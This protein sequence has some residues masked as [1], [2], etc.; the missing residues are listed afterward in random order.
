MSKEMPTCNHTDNNCRLCGGTLKHI[1]NLRIL[2]RYDIN[3]F[4]CE[5]CQ[6]AQTENPYWLDEAYNKANEQNL[7]IGA[8]QRNLH[9]VSACYVIAKLF[10]LKNV[11]DFGG[12]EGLLCRMLR[13]YGANCYVIDKYRE[14]T[15]GKGF[16][17]PDFESPDLLLAFELLEHFPNPKSDLEELFNYNPKVLMFSTEI[18]CKQKQ[19]WWYFALESGQHVFFYSMKSLHFL[20]AKYSYSLLVSGGF[21]I[22]MKEAS[23][24]KRFI[25]KIVLKRRLIRLLR[26]FIPLLPMRGVQTDYL[27]QV[28][29][30]K[31]L[32]SQGDYD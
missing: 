23:H 14:P 18:Y 31:S 13:D 20:A 5:N 3:Y 26:C 12:G 32:F 2:H 28:E 7:D 4:E 22:F 15:Y 6:S 19:D 21:I 1:Y 29:R 24:F 30:S 9:N 25:A 10:G 11:I 8:I 27:Y 16:T 17:K